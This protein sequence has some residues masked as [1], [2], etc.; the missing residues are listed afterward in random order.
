MRKV[1]EKYGTDFTDLP[2]TDD[3]L[4]AINKLLRMEKVASGDKPRL[5][6]MPSNRKEA[7]ELIELLTSG[8]GC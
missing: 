3:Q 1:M 5:I 8:S 6:K 4:R 2:P 7:D